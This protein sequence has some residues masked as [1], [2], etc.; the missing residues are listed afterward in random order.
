MKTL[1]LVLSCLLTLCFPATLVAQV[2]MQTAHEGE[3]S[4]PISAHDI[5]WKQEEEINRYV[6]AHPE[7]MAGA[8]LQKAAAWSFIV[9]STYSWY[10]DDLTTTNTRYTVPATCRA[11]GLTCYVFVEDAGWGARVTQAAVD[12]VVNAFDSAT[13]ANAAKGIF[14]TDVESFGNPPDVDGDPKIIILIL[15]IRD[16]FAGSGGYVAGY[17]YSYNEIPKSTY[18]TSNEAEIYFL[19]CNPLTLTTSSG[20]KTGMST[21]AHEFQHMIHWNYNKLGDTFTNEGCSLMAEVVCGYPLR[22][23]AEFAGEPNH[24]LF[25]WR[26]TDL[27]LV[28]NDYSRAARF[29]LYMKEQFGTPILKTIVGTNLTGSARLDAALAAFTPATSRRFADIFQ[30]WLLANYLNDTGVDP[31][32]G[33]SYPSVTRV[34]P[35]VFLTPNVG[36]T[37]ATVANLG[38]LY[39]SFRSGTSLSTTISSAAPPS[40]FWIRAI[41]TGPAGKRVLP[42][43]LGAQFDE[44]AFGTSYTDVTY[45][46]GGI[47]PS[48][49]RDVTYSSTGTGVVCTELK[50]DVSE[51]SGYLSNAAGDTVC[52]QFDG[53]PGARLDSLRVA[54][55]R[56]GSMTGGIWRYTGSVQPTPLG[57]KLAGPITVTGL[58]TPPSPYPVPWP[59]WGSADVHVLNIDASQPFAAAFVCTGAPAVDNRVMVTRYPSTVAFHSFTYVTS[60]SGWYYYT[61]NAAGDTVFIYVI[62]AYV[63]VPTAVGRETVEL[64]PSSTQLLQNHPNPFNPATT[65]RYSLSSQ[66][67]VT[68]R[69]FDSMGR[70]VATLV[71]GAQPPGRYQTVWEG[72]TNAGIPVASGVY[73]CRLEA[74]SFVKTQRMM[75]LK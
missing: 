41:E 54:L 16:G 42:V 13:P 63:S 3:S 7:V 75:L 20:I 30:D 39:L 58:T 21:T 1:A 62:R 71:R 31:R 29:F 45:V 66:S 47:D 52:V 74:G 73:F 65:I 27:T 55:R 49:P 28:L 61:A 69:I 50:W 60:S 32:W 15:D 18:P 2:I 22:G 53:Y 17:F 10:A 25:D 33:Y 56:T 19:D 23:Q 38:A 26:R 9:G 40:S 44:P 36:S 70:E 37:S 8:R 72:R 68:V 57:A 24:Y 11:V 5:L 51:P 43:S 48:T 34:S 12:S 4:Y 14:Q 46:I 64:L 6:L 35:T 67:E 59:N